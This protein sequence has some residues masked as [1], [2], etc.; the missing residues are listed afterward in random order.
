MIVFWLTGISGAGKTTIAKQVG[1]TIGIPVIDADEVRATVNSDLTLSEEDRHNN[2]Q[3]IARLA[4]Y[5]LKYQDTSSVI[6]TCIAPKKSMRD[7]AVAYLQANNVVTHV[8]HVDS[9]FE[10]CSLRDPKGLYRKSASTM[11]GS[12]ASPYEEPC[13]PSLKVS[14]N[15]LSIQDSVELVSNYITGNNDP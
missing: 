11:T 14:T 8:I 2:V 5:F 12:L 1:A 7:Q 10:T 4:L 3:R 9:D 15:M 13:N 6:V